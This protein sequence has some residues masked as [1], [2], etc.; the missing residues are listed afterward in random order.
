MAKQIRSESDLQRAL[1]RWGDAAFRICYMHTKKPKDAREIMEDVFMQYCLYPR[2][3]PDEDAERFWVLRATHR[4]CMDYY[5]KKLRK[6]PTNAQLQRYGRNLPF[7]VTDELCAVLRLPYTYQTALALCLGEGESPQFAARVTGRPAPLVNRCIDKAAKL[8]GL[9][10]DDLREW[11]ET[12]ETPDDLLGRVQYAILNAMKDKHFGVDSSAQNFKRRLDRSI[13]YIALGVIAVCVVCVVAV[14]AGWFGMP[15]VRT[16]EYLDPDG[17]SSAAGGENASGSGTESGAPDDAS[18]GA[19]GSAGGDTGEESHAA[20]PTP[21]PVDSSGTAAVLDV[22]VFVPSDSGLTQYNLHGV[23]ADASVLV[24][25]MAEKGAFPEDVTLEALAYMQS[26][27]FV[28]ALRSGDQLEMRLQFS[29]ALQTY[30]DSASSAA[31]LEAIA[32]TF[33]AFYEAANMTLAKLEIYSGGAPVTVG[34][35]EINCTALMYGE[36]PVSGVIDE[37]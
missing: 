23:E 32:K 13:P 8:T 2:P 18:S 14:R 27:E 12:I 4:T 10:P 19:E 35:A 6:K 29:E 37:P 22:P 24:E 25:K 34:G 1:L 15:Y 28:T 31:S 20:T 11:V 21:P 16:P 17:T 30:L 26:G 9:C 36:L 5:A 33:R 3:F 7:A